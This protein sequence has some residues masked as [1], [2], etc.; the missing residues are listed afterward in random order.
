VVVRVAWL[1]LLPALVGAESTAL[2][3]DVRALLKPQS[4]GG[5]ALAFGA[6]GLAHGLDDEFSGHIDSELAAPLLDFGNF[7]FG[8]KY[9]VGSTAG[10]WFA[11]RA[12]HRGEIRA[13]SGEVL[14]AL[15]LAGAMVTPLKIA[16]GRQR[17][18]GSNNFSF[19]SGHSAN[20]FAISTVLSRRYGRR[21]G[22]P[23]F[24]LAGF[25]PVA[26]I[27]DRHHFFSDVVAG[28]VL[29]VVAGLAVDRGG[30]ADM[31]FKPVYTKGLWV[32]QASWRY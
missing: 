12:A 19:P 3:R 10:L 6:A 20:A 4:L 2:E 5:I 17:P 15:I 13:A 14:R 22:V 7:Y 28:S 31:A 1:L 8:S 24:A 29:G 32:L 16:A 11:A 18:D 27:H 21:V 26:R 23:L 9:S 30:S 25:V